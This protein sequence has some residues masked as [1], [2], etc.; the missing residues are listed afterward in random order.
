[1]RSLFAV[2]PRTI[3]FHFIAEGDFVVV[4]AKGDNVTKAGVRY[5]NHYCMIWRIENGR[6]EEIREYLDSA[7]F[8]RVLGKFPASGLQA[9]G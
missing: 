8:E 9:A 3:A 6:I 7:L 4:E 5:D 2:P 1:M